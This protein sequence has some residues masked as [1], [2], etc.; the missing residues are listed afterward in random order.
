MDFDEACKYAARVTTQLMLQALKSAL[1]DNPI[2]NKEDVGNVVEVDITKIGPNELTKLHKGKRAFR[3]LV[4]TLFLEMKQSYP[5]PV[6]AFSSA[7]DASEL[8]ASFYVLDLEISL[9][10][11]PLPSS[12]ITI[13]NSKSINNDTMLVDGDSELQQSEM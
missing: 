9:N 4:I 13:S 12:T 6:E 2:Y 3:D 5:S 7:I 1:D 10:E 11:S 8:T